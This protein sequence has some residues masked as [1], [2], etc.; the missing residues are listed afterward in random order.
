MLNLAINALCRPWTDRPRCHASLLIE[1][2]PSGVVRVYDD[3]AGH[4]TT[5]HALSPRTQARLRRLARVE[6][7]REEYESARH[8]EDIDD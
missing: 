2:G 1:D 6:A 8:F 4:Y 5:C 3:V 7:E